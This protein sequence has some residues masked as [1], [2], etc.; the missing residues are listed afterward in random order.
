MPASI[1]ALLERQIIPALR[2]LTDLSLALE[3]GLPAVILLKGDIFD[4]GRVSAQAKGKISVL[5]HIDLMEGIGRD[6]S[7]LAYLKQEFNIAGI[8]STRSN[9]VKEARNLGLIAILRLFV[10]DSAAYSTGL[11]LLQSLKPDAVEMLPGVAVPY[12]KNE[13]IRDFHVPVIASGLIKN[14]ATIK[15]VLAAGAAAVST[16]QPDLWRFK[17]S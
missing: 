13:I 15:Q 3:L 12:L 11:N 17:P 9:L 6:R 7:G 5:L 16:S 14:I 4:I 1:S 10:L 8:V 2:N